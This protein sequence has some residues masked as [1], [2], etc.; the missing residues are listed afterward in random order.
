MIGNHM[1]GF[2]FPNIK[3]LEQQILDHFQNEMQNMQKLGDENQQNIYNDQLA[4][5]SQGVQRE[6]FM[7]MKGKGLG[8]GAMILKL[9]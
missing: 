1:G 2:E 9:T 6:I 5:A 8:P 3:K 7:P 4:K